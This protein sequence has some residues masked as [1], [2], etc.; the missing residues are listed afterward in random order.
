MK[1]VFLPAAVDDL[2]WFRRY[3]QQVFPDGAQKATVQYQKAIHL[4]G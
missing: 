4:L 3:Y 2:E 1:I